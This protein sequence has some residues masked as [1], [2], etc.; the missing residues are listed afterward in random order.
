MT[1]RTGL[2]IFDMLLLPVYSLC[3]WSLLYVIGF[4]RIGPT[5][6]LRDANILFARPLMM[7]LSIPVI[8]APEAKS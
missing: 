4:C 5:S 8:R 1:S 3:L 2:C 6:T 7:A